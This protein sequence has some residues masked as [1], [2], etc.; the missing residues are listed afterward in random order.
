MMAQEFRG[1]VIFGDHHGGEGDDID[2]RGYD[3]HD[4]EEISEMGTVDVTLREAGVIL[5]GL[6]FL[7]EEDFTPFHEESDDY[8][9]K[10][11]EWWL[12][13]QKGINDWG[14]QHHSVG[15][16]G[17]QEDGSDFV[18]D[19]DDGE[20]AEDIDLFALEMLGR[21]VIDEKGQESAEDQI[22][23]DVETEIAVL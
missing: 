13:G 7:D 8:E 18:K 5:I 20:K 3:D 1:E 15:G 9:D 6:A 16:E 17:L 12:R 19:G 14:K 21:P 23:E 10:E 22:D 2:D 11:G 4:D